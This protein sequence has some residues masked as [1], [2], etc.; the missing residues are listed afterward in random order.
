M[1][2]RWR[3][4]LTKLEQQNLISSHSGNLNYYLQI[5][6]LKYSV[7]QIGQSDFFFLVQQENQATSYFLSQISLRDQKQK[8]WMLNTAFPVEYESTLIGQNPIFFLLPIKKEHFPIITLNQVSIFPLKSN[9]RP[10]F[11]LLSSH[12]FA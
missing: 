3:Q 5:V 6:T 7:N 10:P 1:A 4:F 2:S 12:L 8:D 9:F 11:V